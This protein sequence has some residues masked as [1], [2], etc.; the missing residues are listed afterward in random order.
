MKI[1]IVSSDRT[2]DLG[3]AINTGDALL[4]DAIVTRLVAANHDVTVGDFGAVR[5]NADYSRTRITGIFG[6]ISL[7][8][9]HDAV[10]IGGGTMIQEDA[11]NLLRGSLMRLCLAVSVAGWISRVKVVFFAVGCDPLPRRM[12]RIGYALAVGRKRVWVREAESAD[13]FTKY[14][15][16]TPLIG[17]DAALLLP[18]VPPNQDNGQAG[19]LLLAPNYKDAETLV[20][21]WISGMREEFGEVV[22]M[23]MSSG[24]IDDLGLVP[25]QSL[26]AVVSASTAAG[27]RDVMTQFRPARAVVASRMHALYVA[28]LQ[29]IPMVAVGSS[30]KI[31]AFANE[32]EIPRVNKFDEFRPGMERLAASKPLQEATTRVEISFTDM[33]RVLEG[34]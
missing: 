13:R 5:S 27:W 18:Q 28:M 2:S 14:F 10:I 25:A 17:A 11:S 1:L 33:L 12:A 29:G 19:A 15:R 30:P 34:R 31:V 9:E 4:T 7:V 8:R 3:H 32:F 20:L 16:R 22:I 23:P 24:A 21:N 6:L 26:E